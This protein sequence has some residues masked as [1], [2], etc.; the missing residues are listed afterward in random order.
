[1]STREQIADEILNESFAPDTSDPALLDARTIL[2][3]LGALSIRAIESME[4][5]T[6]TEVDVHDV[7]NDSL[8]RDIGHEL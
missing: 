8:G 6:V 2:V 4:T 5:V 3:R 1:M 7:N